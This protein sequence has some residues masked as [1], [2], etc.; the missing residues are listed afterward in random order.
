MPRLFFKSFV[1][2]VPQKN[3]GCCRK[4][5]RGGFLLI[6]AEDKR[7][8]SHEETLEQHGGKTDLFRGTNVTS[9]KGGRKRGKANNL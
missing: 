8:S 2:S 7:P 6:Q 9:E 5:S 1:K 3:E 4:R